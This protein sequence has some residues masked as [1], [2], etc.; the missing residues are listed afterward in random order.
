MLLYKHAIRWKT[1]K[2][3]FPL[4]IG[5]VLIDKKNYQFNKWVDTY[6]VLS[7]QYSM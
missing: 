3:Y 7:A 1:A 5:G 6:I 2:N 4:S